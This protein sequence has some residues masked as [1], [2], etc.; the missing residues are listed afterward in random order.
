MIIYLIS[1]NILFNNLIDYHTFFNI[2]YCSK[3][4]I[5]MNIKLKLVFRNL[6]I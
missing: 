3:V 1:F 4:V 2:K 5:F 6:L